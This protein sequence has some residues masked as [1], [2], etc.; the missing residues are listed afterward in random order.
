VIETLFPPVQRGL[1]FVGLLGLGG[2]AAWRLWI[3]PTLRAESE[4]VAALED[5]VARAGFWLTVGLLP[6]WA[7]RLE[8]QLLGFRDPFVPWIEDASFLVLETFW[9]WSWM[10]QG[11]LMILLA[12]V[13]YRWRGRLGAL[14]RPAYAIPLLVAG[15]AL[16]QAL[17]SHAMSVPFNRWVA[18]GLDAVHL[19]VAGGWMGSLAL[20][21][22][23]TR[24]DKALWLP[25]QLRAFSPVAMGSVAFLVFSG[26]QLSAQHVMAWENLWGSAYGRVLVLKIGIALVVLALGGWNWRRGL[27]ALGTPHGD[28]QVRNRAAVEVVAAL[29]VVAVT[30]VLTGMS[31]PEGTH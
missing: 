23:V 12:L 8:S 16:T 17:A 19:L 30:A 6:L 28:R 11:V 14:D 10:V 4:P 1:F 29:A 18:V 3:G 26:V 22:W 9:G 2:V 24:G 31:M 15:I 20:I 25:A 21:L 5:A 7:A 13:L 27:P